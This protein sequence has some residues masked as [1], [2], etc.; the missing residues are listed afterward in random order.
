[1]K[2]T[3]PRVPRLARSTSLHHGQGEAARVAQQNQLHALGGGLGLSAEHL[4]EVALEA[5]HGL[6]QGELPSEH[7][8]AP[9]GDASAVGDEAFQEPA[10]LGLVLQAVLG[11]GGPS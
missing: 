3:L 11:A 6:V 8:Q 4:A 9:G 2:T 10:D 7:V 1:M 5:H